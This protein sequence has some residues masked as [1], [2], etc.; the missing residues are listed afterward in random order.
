MGLLEPAEKRRHDSINEKA[1]DREQKEKQFLKEKN[2]RLNYDIQAKYPEMPPTDI[3][4]HSVSS[5]RLFM[6]MFGMNDLDSRT[7][8]FQ[9]ENSTEISMRIRA[10]DLLKEYIKFWRE[11]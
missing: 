7:R 3:S 8:I 11:K 4:P 10:L 1:K 5:S 2:F 9:L 6:S